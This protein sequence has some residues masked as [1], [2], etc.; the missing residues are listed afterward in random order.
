M[1]NRLA[2]LLERRRIE[3]NWALSFFGG[4]R[5]YTEIQI[6]ADSE[7]AKVGCA[8]ILS[9]ISCSYECISVVFGL[10]YF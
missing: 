1:S 8:P 9:G 3:K 5:A 7:I 4:K 2:S 6:R 10:L